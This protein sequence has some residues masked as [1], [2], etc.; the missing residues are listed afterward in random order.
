MTYLEDA[1]IWVPNT[2]LVE[3]V[4]RYTV[5]LLPATLSQ[6]TEVYYR[7]AV[8]GDWYALNTCGGDGRLLKFRIVQ[9]VKTEHSTW[10]AVKARY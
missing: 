7:P 2:R 10:G 5:A 4:D 1:Q 8:N 3:T 6:Y 9:P